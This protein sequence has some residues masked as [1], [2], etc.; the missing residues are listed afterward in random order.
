MLWG[1]STSAGPG[2][3]VKVNGLQVMDFTQFQD[4]LA[5][6]LVDSVRRLNFDHKWLFQ[7]YNNPKHTSKWLFCYIIHI[8][9]SPSRSLDLKSIENLWFELRRTVH[10]NKQTMKELKVFWM[11]EWSKI[12]PNVFS[13]LI[14]HF[15]KRLSIML[16]QWFSI[17]GLG[18]Q[19]GAHFCFCPSTTHLIEIIK[20][21]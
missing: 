3:L 2:G 19:R 18:T 5:N 4:I 13:N 17:L 11:E 15:R 10:K 8:L 7:Q 16:E 14:K 6:N 9:Q 12:P 20:A 1:C 21:F